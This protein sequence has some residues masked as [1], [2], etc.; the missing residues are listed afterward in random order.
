[1]RKIMAFLAGFMLVFVP[2]V[3]QGQSATRL[4]AMRYV[5]EG[6]NFLRIGNWEQ[7]LNSYFNAIQADPGYADAYMKRSSL[8]EILGRYSEASIDY[9][10]AVRLNPY[11]VAI[12]DKRRRITMLAT[13]YKGALHGLGTDSPVS[14]DDDHF[15]DHRVDD[16]IELGM[17]QEAIR[18]IDTLLALGYN[19]QYE[20][21]KKA[22]I[23]LLLGDFTNS[24][25]AAREIT[26]EYPYSFLAFD[27]LGVS[28]MRQD[29]T[30]EAITAF[31]R[32]IQINPAFPLSWFNR[33]I[34][35]RM[36]G[37]FDKAMSD[38]NYA[39]QLGQEVSSAYFLRALLYKEEGNFEMAINEYDRIL[40][41]DDAHTAALYNRS[42]TYKLLGDY[43]SALR[44]AESILALDPSSAE[45]WNLKGNIQVLFG[46]YYD[47][48]ESFT[49]ALGYNPD[50]AEA[51]YNRG[52]TNLL[53]YSATQAC[54]DLH[55]GMILGYARA[56]D[57]LDAFCGR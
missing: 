48:I 56:G 34:A 8:N 55:S 5:R 20:L 7:A 39:L 22:L 2:V 27:I 33:A 52:I 18:D 51:Y 45:H 54:Q 42:F 21:E 47:A 25:N 28:A 29:R 57:I 46:D 31:S 24:E 43:S 1:M 9:D 49:R 36:K 17:Y 41:A 13:H 26:I 12:F 3:L 11:S 50:Y 23:F 16:F 37:N 35:Y 10:I 40:R 19:K 53:L 14:S 6:D 15:I 38:L 44:D 4:E 30:D 32:S